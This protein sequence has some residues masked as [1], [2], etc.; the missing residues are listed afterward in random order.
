MQ[1]QR[2][3]PPDGTITDGM[4]GVGSRMRTLRK[5]F[6]FSQD[7]LA[8]ALGVVQQS[9]SAWENDQQR[10]SLP[11]LWAFCSLLHV[12]ADLVLGLPGDGLYDC[13]DEDE[14]IVIDPPGVSE[15]TEIHDLVRGDL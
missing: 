8:H 3:N 7:K 12:S 15:L 11:M 1:N 14:R 9:V 5:A 6:G 13:C 2:N 10:P 4:P